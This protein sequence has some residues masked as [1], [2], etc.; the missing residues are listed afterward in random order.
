MKT[1]RKELFRQLEPPPGGVRRMGARMA[2]PSIHVS[3]IQWG[4]ATACILV[5]AVGI[6]VVTSE[7]RDVIA[8]EVS[9][10][11]IA[12]SPQFDRL[13]GREAAPVELTVQRNDQAVA[14]TEVA[15]SNPKV[16]IY[17]LN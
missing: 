1:D 2:A 14:L 6:L 16:R 12:A 8:P 9:A 7:P 15:S 5:L 17:A 10:D 11:P 13:L 4:L 3:P